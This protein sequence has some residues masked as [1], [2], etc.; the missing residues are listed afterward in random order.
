MATT[1]K[2][3]TEEALAVKEDASLELYDYGEAE[4]QGFEDQSAEDYALPFITLL[5]Q[6]SPQCDDS[7]DRYIKGAKPGMYYNSATDELYDEFDAVICATKNVW[8]EYIKRED[9]G[10][11]VGKHSRDDEVVQTALANCEFG[12]FETPDG[13]D[14]IDTREAYLMLLDK[15]TEPV[16]GAVFPFTSSKIKPY[17]KLITQ[18][19]SFTLKTKEGRK[20]KPPMFAHRIRFS[21]VKQK[22]KQGQP[23][24]NVVVGPAA[25]APA[26]SLLP[27]K[28]PALEAAADFRDLIHRGEKSSDYS[29]APAQGAESG[30]DGE[31]PF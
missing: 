4:G 7:D 31:A 9:G 14:L 28:H 22:N 18:L 26:D 2:K 20:V 8:I 24:F 25:G 5:Q 1:K 19:S 23:F 17:K 10:G 21:S 6:L 13:H 11:F 12:Q 29:K 3:K 30:G 16:G 15:N 27:P